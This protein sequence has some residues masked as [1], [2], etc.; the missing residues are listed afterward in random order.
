M[1][2]RPKIKPEQSAFDIILEISGW[3]VLSLLWIITLYF[4]KNLPDNIPT[5]FNAAGEVDAYGNRSSILLL[6]VIGTVLF[7]GMTILNRYPYI[8]NYPVK[9]S[10]EN[11][12]KQYTMATRLIRLLKLSI[13]IIFIMIIWST[14]NVALEKS[15]RMGAWF[16]PVMLGIIFIPMG[17]YI[18]RSFRLK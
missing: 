12:T 3:V 1:E 6:P 5:H 10:P 16:L 15:S 8:F 13:L 18:F 7:I 11:A 4:F 17:F 14:S 9:I 2:T